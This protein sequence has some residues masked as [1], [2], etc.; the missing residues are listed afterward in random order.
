MATQDVRLA[1]TTTALLFSLFQISARMSCSDRPGTP[2]Q[3]NATARHQV[4][5]DGKRATREI[6]F[7]WRNTAKHGETVWWDIEMTDGNGNVIPQR[8]G[9]GRPSSVHYEELYNAYLVGPRTTRCFRIKARTGAGTSGCVSQDWS[10]R[11]CARSSAPGP[12]EIQEKHV[13]R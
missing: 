3:V 2:D 13:V 1:L 9:A 7:K 12:G 11:V 5:P 10:A 4:N 8:A 6:I